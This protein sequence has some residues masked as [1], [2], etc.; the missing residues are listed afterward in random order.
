MTDAIDQPAEENLTDLLDQTLAQESETGSAQ[1]H[2]G[3]SIK[4]ARLAR[5]LAD[6]PEVSRLVEQAIRSL[7]QATTAIRRDA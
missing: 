5:D 7:Q 4:Q 6:D 3:C 1:S 2:L